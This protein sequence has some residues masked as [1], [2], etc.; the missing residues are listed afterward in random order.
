MEIKLDNGKLETFEVRLFTRN[1]DTTS[2][3][4]FRSGNIYISCP[5]EQSSLFFRAFP[6]ISIY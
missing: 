2:S 5:G 3:T 6:A 4:A 1:T